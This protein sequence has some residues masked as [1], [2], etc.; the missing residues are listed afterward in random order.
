MFGI[1]PAETESWL[2]GRGFKLID[3]ADA[4]EYRNRHVTPVGRELNIYEGEKM[5]LAK[6]TG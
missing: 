1:D 5:V 6:V 3:Q 2:S 4:V